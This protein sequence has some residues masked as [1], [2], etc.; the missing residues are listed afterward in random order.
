MKLASRPATSKHE[1]DSPSAGGKV[2]V[3]GPPSD[4]PSTVY[5][6]PSAW[7]RL[8]VFL[9]PSASRTDLPSC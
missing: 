6:K 5:E 8:P 9:A 2:G 7:R 3:R 1:D 4:Y